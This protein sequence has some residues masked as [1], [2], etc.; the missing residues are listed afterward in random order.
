MWALLRQRL[1]ETAPEEL[2]SRGDFLKRL[3]RAVTWLNEVY[4]DKL[5]HLCWNQKDRARDVKKLKG[6]KTKW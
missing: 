4:K 5:Q 2:E 6:A 3:R 1:D